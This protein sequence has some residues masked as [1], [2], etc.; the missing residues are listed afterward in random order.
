M[1]ETARIYTTGAAARHFGVEMW[2]IRRL[3]ERGMLVPSAKVGA[4]R[5]FTE[6]DLWRVGAALKSAGYLKSEEAAPCP[7]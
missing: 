6:G 7:A 4:Y 5:V 3:V 1:P 2:K